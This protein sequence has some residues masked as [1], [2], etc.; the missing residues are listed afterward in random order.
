MGEITRD[1]KGLPSPQQLYAA[2]L[3]R[4]RDKLFGERE[5]MGNVLEEIQAHIMGSI[6][7]SNGVSTITMYWTSPPL[8]A[9]KDFE[10]QAKREVLYILR[11]WLGLYGYKLVQGRA[12]VPIQRGL[13]GWLVT[14]VRCHIARC[15]T[16][17]GWAIAT[18]MGLM[19]GTIMGIVF[20]VRFLI[21]GF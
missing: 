3:E 10:P 17:E 4:D 13:W 2:K 20:G 18:G 5:Q 12:I 11:R 9:L 15:D 6:E 7:E 16:S 19:F 8:V 21:V 1:I 14:K